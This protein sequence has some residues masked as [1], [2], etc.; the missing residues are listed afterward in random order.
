MTSEL[1]QVFAHIWPRLAGPGRQPKQP[2]FGSS[3]YWNYRPQSESLEPLIGFPAFL[4]PKVWLN[5]QNLGKKS[6]PTKG[7]L[8]H[9][10][11]K[12]ITRQPI[13]LES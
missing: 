6:S 9:F 1:G 7:N 3:F 8:G 10:P 4:K 12:A 5:N 2:F 11:I 13:E